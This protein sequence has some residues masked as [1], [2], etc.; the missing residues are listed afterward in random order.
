MC[1]RWVQRTAH[2]FLF[3]KT[4]TCWGQKI[5]VVMKISHNHNNLSGYDK[6]R[7]LDCAKNWEGEFHSALAVPSR[8][9]PRLPRKKKGKLCLKSEFWFWCVSRVLVF[10]APFSVSTFRM[11]KKYE[12][13]IA[14]FAFCRKKL[15][16][17][18]REEDPCV[19]HSDLF[20]RKD[21]VI[22]F[23]HRPDS[24]V[25]AKSRGLFF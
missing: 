14:Q 2:T 10:L 9:S 12:S 8:N 6:M 13:A 25:D 24:D 7:C 11:E 16:K 20:C 18:N 5:S 1:L 3:D 21:Y 15:S 4:S 19:L 23:L 22:L 17:T